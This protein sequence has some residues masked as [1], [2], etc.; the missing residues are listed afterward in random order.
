MTEQVEDPIAS[1]LETVGSDAEYFVVMMEDALKN[2]REDADNTRVQLAKLTK[3]Q[4]E[5]EKAQ[6]KES[7]QLREELDEKD[8][9]WRASVLKGQSTL[10]REGYETMCR[11]TVMTAELYSANAR[12]HEVLLAVH[13]IF[14]ARELKKD[15]R[16]DAF[17]S[18]RKLFYKG[19]KVVVPTDWNE[20]GKLKTKVKSLTDDLE[21]E[22]LDLKRFHGWW[23]MWSTFLEIEDNAHRRVGI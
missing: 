15:K 7:K 1:A 8:V 2:A 19:R 17:V 10:R 4:E 21:I 20:L 5:M 11:V 22:K 6:T 18:I 14:K 12:Y 3:V 9:A 16:A 23:M 13:H